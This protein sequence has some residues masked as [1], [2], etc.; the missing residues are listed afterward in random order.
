[1]L[2][3]TARLVSAVFIEVPSEHQVHYRPLV[4]N[5]NDRT[6]A[7]IDEATEGGLH[8]NVQ[9]FTPMVGQILAPSQQSQGMFNLPYGWNHKRHS[10]VLT[11]EVT[12]PM[13]TTREMFTGFT[14]Y[15]DPSL[16]STRLAP[17]TPIYP[18]NWTSIKLRTFN[19]RGHTFQQY[20]GDG[21]RQLLAPV[22]VNSYADGDVV[23]DRP[24]RPI[25]AVAVGQMHRNYLTTE[26]VA[27]S[28]RSMQLDHLTSSRDNLIGSHYVSKLW[29]GYK[30]AV[31]NNATIANDEGWMMGAT[32]ENLAERSAFSSP[33][34]RR[35]KDSCEN[36]N[37]GYFVT[38][39]ELAHAFPEVNRPD[40]C[41]VKALNPALP[42]TTTDYT[43]EWNGANR[44]TQL[45]YMLSQAV[46]AITG[47][48]LMT[49]IS[50]T[51]ENLST[52]GQSATAVIHGFQFAASL[53]DEVHRLQLIEIALVTDIAAQLQAYNVA[54]FFIKYRTNIMG[55]TQIEIAINGGRTFNF[56]LPTY[57][58]SYYTP[59]VSAGPGAVSQ[60]AS[61][62]DNMFSKVY[63]YRY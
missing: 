43:N 52:G 51:L 40:V 48:K 61:D 34:L 54:D 15:S 18:N 38:F 28:R 49:Q 55:S 50:F 35:L 10:M 17:D 16:L 21:T 39:G 29:E 7:M 63:S 5:M 58:D 8:T 62:V 6:I 53:P 41:Q 46:S 36:F 47:E 2:T 11:F 3:S 4:S 56:S 1:M 33:I 45:A 59:M 14:G 30:T 23:A 42:Q 12:T 31:A 25:D 27:D 60:L 24:L 32:A 22:H 57:C 26:D 9:R 37:G 20:T 13:G 19:D 44:E